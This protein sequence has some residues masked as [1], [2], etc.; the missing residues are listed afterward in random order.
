MLG[1]ARSPAPRGKGLQVASAELAP[2]IP[3]RVPAS[4]DDEL[5]VLR[6]AVDLPRLIEAGYDAGLHV[7][8]P[9]VDHPVFGYQ[10]CP[11]AGCMA[12]V[13]AG[14]LCYGCRQRFRRF[15][16]SLDEFMAIPRVFALSRRGEQ[17]LC[18]VCRTPSTS[19]RPPGATGSV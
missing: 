8:R 11:V 4:G 5:S 10:L 18:I 9:P 12:A 15:D 14:T 17:R 13:V 19:A 16:G 2:V 3:L 1:R 6:R 7:I